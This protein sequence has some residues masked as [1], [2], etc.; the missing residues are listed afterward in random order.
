MKPTIPDSVIDEIR[1]LA[2]QNPTRGYQKAIA[3]KFG[4]SAPYVNLVIKGL[5]R[6]LP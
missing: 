2:A 4:L 1:R 3:K 6:K 5:R